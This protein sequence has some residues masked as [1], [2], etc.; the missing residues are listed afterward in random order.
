MLFYPVH[1]AGL[2]FPAWR[3][4]PACC[5]AGSSRSRASCRE[6]SAGRESSRRA[7]RRWARSR[8]TRGSRSSGAPAD[9]SSSSSRNRSPSTSSPRRAATSATSSSGSCE[10]ENPRLW[11][12]MPPRVREAVHARV[13]QQL[14]DIV[15]AVTDEIGAQHRPAARREADGHPTDRGAARARQPHLPRGRAQGAALHRQLRVLLRLLLGI[16]QVDPHR[17]SL[18]HWWVLRSAA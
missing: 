2:G 12:D 4:S 14:P 7:P 9:F 1:F 10:R 5:R 8:S 15:R 18:P 6:A 11:N 13:Q 17:E 16:P 3:R